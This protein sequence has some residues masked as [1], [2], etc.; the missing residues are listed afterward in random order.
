[1]LL[2][3]YFLQFYVI[4]LHTVNPYKDD[5]EKSIVRIQAPYLKYF[6]KRVIKFKI[7]L[8]EN[9]G[10]PVEFYRNLKTE[11]NYLLDILRIPYGSGFKNNTGNRSAIF[12]IHPLSGSGEIYL[13][14]KNSIGFKLAD[15][16]FD[17][18]VAFTRGSKYSRKHLYF[19][20]ITHDSSYWLYSYVW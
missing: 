16:G 4:Y 17:V 1:M 7:N 19:K 20:N 9:R 8:T 5:H 6:I 15:A 2:Y 13:V 10:Y 11:D 14:L 3:L 18:W 12:L